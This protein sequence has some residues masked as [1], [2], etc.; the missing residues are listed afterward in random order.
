MPRPARARTTLQPSLSG[1][2]GQSLPPGARARIDCK[3]WAPVHCISFSPDGRILA[4]AGIDGIHLWNVA[5]RKRLESPTGHAF[6]AGHVGAVETLAYSPDGRLL[7]SGGED[8]TVR[9]WDPATGK[10]VAK[11]VGLLTDEGRGGPF[12]LYPSTAKECARIDRHPSSIV[13]VAFSTDGKRLVAMHDLPLARV[14]DVGTGKLIRE[15]AQAEGGVAFSPEG[16]HLAVGGIEGRVRILDA[17]TYRKLREFEVNGPDG[18][19]AF[20]PDGKLLATSGGTYPPALLRG[21]LW[22]VGTGKPVPMTMTGMAGR[23]I[24]AVAFSP[25][26]KLLAMANREGIRLCD[27]HS[28]KEIAHLDGHGERGIDSI[29]FSPDGETLASG[30][31]DASIL[32]WNIPRLQKPEDL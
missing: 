15:I 11:F 19:L 27:I 9:L 20:S 4:W 29:A 14:W 13:G 30:N 2:A 17:V 21:C 32:L 12:N 5:S 31:T 25:D 24:R 22:T 23:V 26:G 18:D 3:P 28:G 1:P 7:A 16:K 8:G 10:A 6:L